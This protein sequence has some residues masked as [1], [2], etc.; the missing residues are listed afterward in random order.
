MYIILLMEYLE[1][2]YLGVEYL[3]M[4]YILCLGIID[5]ILIPQM[6][7]QQ[8][9]SL[10]APPQPALFLSSRIMTTPSVMTSASAAVPLLGCW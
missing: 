1:V 3:G 8:C 6:V 4:I 7:N 2:K 5:R 9:I 10:I